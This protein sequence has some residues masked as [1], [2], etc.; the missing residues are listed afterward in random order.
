MTE[1]VEGFLSEWASAERAGDTAKL[2][3]LLTED[4]TAVGPL[5]FILPRQGW[6]A[7]HRDGDL[8]YQTFTVDEVQARLLGEAAVVTARNNTRGSYRGHPVPEAVRATV[9][10][11]SHAGEWKLAAMHMSF[12]AGTPGAPSIPG[13]TSHPASEKSIA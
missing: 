9:I 6:L 10:L 1:P 2:E 5:G 7:R 4:F 13:A 3:T 11:V 8:T 12:I